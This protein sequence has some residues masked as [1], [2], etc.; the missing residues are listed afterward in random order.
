MPDTIFEGVVHK[1]ILCLIL[2]F[3]SPLGASDFVSA[4]Q[5]FPVASR[6]DGLAGTQWLTSVQ[7][8]N[9]QAEDLTITARLSA[10]GSFQTETIVI[11]A[12]ETRGW[13]DFLGDVF[14]FDGNGALFLEAGASSNGQV[15]P[16]FRSFAVSMRISTQGDNGGSFGQGVPSLD[17]VSGFL[18][19]WVAYFPG[20]QLWGQPG[21][22]G[23]RT[24]VGFWNVGPE[25]A[26][27]SLRIFDSTGVEV[28]SQSVGAPQHRPLVMALPRDLDLETATLVV[29]PL[30]G[31]LDCA[32]YISVVD[33]LTGDGVFLTSQLM[34]PDPSV[35]GADH[36]K[37]DLDRL[38]S[39]IVG[40]IQ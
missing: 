1:Y 5:F 10:G 12:G 18:G 11:T 28:W 31:W 3:A 38:R 26:Q 40:E 21:V 27:M 15:A 29:E 25:N 6:T 23:F 19:D 9:P 22:D 17:P 24:N 36:P 34:D 13:A 16:E 30:G 37:Q 7:I 14:A 4:T 39:L 32:V 33:N 20:V 8:V 35:A 2:V